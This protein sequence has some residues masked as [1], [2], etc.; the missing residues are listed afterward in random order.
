VY[1]ALSDKIIYNIITDATRQCKTKCVRDAFFWRHAV[2]VFLVAGCAS[3]PKEAKGPEWVWKGSGAFD[4]DKGKVFYGVGIASDIKNKALLRTTA[5]N[6]ARAEIAKTLETYVAVLAKD[7]MAS[8]SAGA[9]AVSPDEQHVEEA[10][11]TFSKT[12]LHG[13]IIVDR[14]LDRE[15]G[16]FYSLCE[17]DMLAFKDA[18]DNYKELDSKVRDYIRKNAEKM[19]SE[20]EKMEEK[21]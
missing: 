21:K 11:K 5:D 15:V 7:Y 12:T 3:T 8:T 4:A 1:I 2:G 6:R 14:W 9:M 18:L 10:L 19:H 17:L 16:I 13:A 20:L